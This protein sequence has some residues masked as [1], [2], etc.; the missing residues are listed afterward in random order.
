LA[1]NT[2]KGEII[3]EESLTESNRG[4]KHRAGVFMETDGIVGVMYLAELLKASLLAEIV[5]SDHQKKSMGVI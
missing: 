5:V 4:G 3:L 2:K 1:P